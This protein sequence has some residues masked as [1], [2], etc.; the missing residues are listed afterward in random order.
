VT[1]ITDEDQFLLL[2]CDGLFDVY[3]P[4]E[5]VVFVREQMIKHGDAQKCCQ[6]RGELYCA[7]NFIGN[8]LPFACLLLRLYSYRPAHCMYDECFLWCSVDARECLT[9]LPF[10]C[11][12]SIQ[13]LTHD[14]IR[15]RNSRDNVS[16]I[17]II[18]N[19]WY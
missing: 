2:G 3:T 13:S 7:E 1:T 15:K 11:H 8:A 12:F 4:E 18:L 5:V 19:K 16:V 17:L 14:A 9:L 6:V 10:P